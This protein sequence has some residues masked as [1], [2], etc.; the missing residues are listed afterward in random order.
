[1]KEREE[2]VWKPFQMEL[3]VRKGLIWAIHR[4]WSKSDYYWSVQVD[5]SRISTVT[6]R[7]KPVS[8]DTKSFSTYHLVQDGSST[9]LLSNWYT[10]LIP[11]SIPWYGKILDSVNKIC[12]WNDVSCMAQFSY[13]KVS[14]YWGVTLDIFLFISTLLTSLQKRFAQGAPHFLTKIIGLPTCVL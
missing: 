1:M 4:W 8:D 9:G 7:Y 10:L 14:A 12:Y 6:K 5:N 2:R 11:V 13:Y 3:T